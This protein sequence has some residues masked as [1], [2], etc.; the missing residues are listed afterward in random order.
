MKK[1]LLNI[2]S[3][4]ILFPAS[5]SAIDLDDLQIEDGFQISVFAEGLDSPRQ[6]VE[7]SEE[8][9]LLEKEMG[10]LLL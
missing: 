2:F 4:I 5:L 1:F 10:R 8:Q 7:G 6:M 3:A 9:F